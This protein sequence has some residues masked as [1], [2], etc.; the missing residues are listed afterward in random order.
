MARQV[1]LAIS[2][3]DICEGQDLGEGLY[4]FML[5]QH[6][7]GIWGTRSPGPLPSMKG[8]QTEC[9]LGHPGPE[10]AGPLTSRPKEA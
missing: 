6:T 2:G 3:G 8:N 9:E 1:V 10:T 4:S 5:P 7:L